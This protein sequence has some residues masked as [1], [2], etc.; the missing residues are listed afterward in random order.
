MLHVLF[1]YNI[2]V[3]YT[4]THTHTYIRA[5]TN[6]NIDYQ[7]VCQLFSLLIY[8]MFQYDVTADSPKISTLL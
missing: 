8:Y 1:C 3:G 6:N 7:F 5:A 4:H 2:Y